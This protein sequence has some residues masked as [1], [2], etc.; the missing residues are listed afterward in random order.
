MVRY[1][2]NLDF[3][4]FHPELYESASSP[5]L[6][7][8]GLGLS[9]DSVDWRALGRVTDIKNQGSCGSCWAFASTGQYESLIAIATNGTKYN[10]AEQ[11][12]L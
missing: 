6:L 10:L 3:F 9:P 5:P 2:S 7:G 4:N 11:Y 12:G 1:F 8:S